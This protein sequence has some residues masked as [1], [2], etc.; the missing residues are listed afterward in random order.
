MNSSDLIELKKRSWDRAIY[1]HGT[2]YVFG[3]RAEKYRRSLRAITFLGVLVPLSVG[4][5]V[6]AYGTKSEI[7]TNIVM[8]I[9]SFFGIIQI[10]LSG[11]SLSS[12]WDDEYASSLYSLERNTY[13]RFE[14]EN[15]AKGDEEN[16]A[17]KF[18]ILNKE[19]QLQE[20]SDIKKGISEKEKRIA[21]R[22]GLM[23]YQREC[24]GCNKIP[25]SMSSS[26]CVIC[27]NF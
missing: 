11:W 6:L 19:D 20:Q 14:W 3:K 16:I 12:K 24:I 27:G 13:L 17:R 4:G 8:P 9:V 18:D 26:N 1:A 7:L 21:M 15:L 2:A 5:A 23:Q 22:A 25:K 10:I